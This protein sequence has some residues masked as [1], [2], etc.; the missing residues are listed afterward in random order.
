MLPPSKRAPLISNDEGEDACTQAVLPPPSLRVATPAPVIARFDVGDDGDEEQTCVMPSKVITIP[1]PQRPSTDLSDRRRPSVRAALAASGTEEPSMTSYRPPSNALTSPGGRVR[2][3]TVPPPFSRRAPTT[4]P[5]PPVS[6][7]APATL[8]PPPAPPLRTFPPPTYASTP[9]EPMMPVMLAQ[10]IT[11]GG[12][13]PRALPTPLQALSPERIQAQI[14]AARAAREALGSYPQYDFPSQVGAPRAPDSGILEV[15]PMAVSSPRVL[16]PRKTTP[17]WAIALVSVGLLGGLVSAVIARGDANGL[18]RAGMSFVEPSHTEAHLSAAAAQPPAP[19]KASDDAAAIA[20]PIA[21]PAATPLAAFAPP[22]DK[23]DKA[24][25]NA[26]TDKTTDK[27]DKAPKPE[28]RVASHRAAASAPTTTTRATP[29]AAPTPIPMDRAVAE[30]QAAP[31]PE[32][33]APNAK[34]PAKNA[35]AVDADL[36]SAAA[37]EALAK[38]QLDQSL[39]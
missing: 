28:V 30:K 11:L 20:K 5:P 18:V 24:D 12:G 37:A 34:R 17:A 16:A 39:N 4:T 3:V 38:A 13:A 10:P 7:R 8:P 35:T 6:T 26:K 9:D 25:K 15:P 27:A 32:K 14:E 2:P 21:R 36:A 22:S 19:A 23:A 29:S 1:P 33:S 31:A